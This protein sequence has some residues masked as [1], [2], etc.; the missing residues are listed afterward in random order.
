MGPMGP[1][2]N[3]ANGPNW[4]PGP[5]SGNLSM[6]SKNSRAGFLNITKLTWDIICTYI[7]IYR[8]PSL[9]PTSRTRCLGIF[10]DKTVDVCGGHAKTVDVCGGRAG[11]N[12]KMVDVCGG[13]AKTS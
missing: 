3:W 1:V 5:N 10:I 6:V 4:D 12:I 8:L 7:Y 9:P 2:P 11:S 13:R